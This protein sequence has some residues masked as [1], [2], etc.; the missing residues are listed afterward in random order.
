MRVLLAVGSTRTATIDGISAAG[1]DPEA[2]LQTPA[3]DAELVAY[4]RPVSD[5]PVPVSPS[6]CPTPALITRAVR[7]LIEF[8]LLVLD[9]GLAVRTAAPT[10]AI[11]N[12]PSADVRE[13]EALH[14]ARSIYD[15]ARKLVS[16]LPDDEIVIGESV[17]GGTTTALGVLRALG[18]PFGVSSSLPENPLPLK[19][20]V[21]AEGLEASGLDPGDAA[22]AP[23]RALRTMGDPA[24][25][26][27]AG[28][29]A[30]AAEA[31][32]EVTLAGGTQLVAAAALARH[33]GIDHPLTLA[34][35]SFLA[36]TE[37]V[38][39]QRAAAR[40]DLELS[41]TDPRFD[42]A[43]HP[44]LDGYVRGEAKEGVGMGGALRLTDRRDI[45]MADVRRRVTD[46]YEA[47]VTDGS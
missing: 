31:G 33:G 18:K 5:L 2:V 25:A 10:V 39:L 37:G 13:A 14:A 34:T 22:D 16:G 4:G 47:L 1:A 15:A 28:S 23:L 7:E 17:P 21:V 45:P 26:A 46:R 9:A 32:S 11:G 40:L 30:G 36:D 19:E 6:G 20:R 43:D 44:A 8:G 24:L 41:V 42:Q 38:D 35:T 3:A 29:I 12:E 27:V